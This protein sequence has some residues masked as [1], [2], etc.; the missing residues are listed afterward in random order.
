[1]SVKHK[2]GPWRI[3]SVPT[4]ATVNE[5]CLIV[6]EDGTPI[7][8]IS[9]DGGGTEEEI[10]ECVANAHLIEAAPN[11]EAKFLDVL[12]ELQVLVD[13]WAEHRT[14]TIEP[15]SVWAARVIA[16]IERVTG[17]KASDV[18]RADDGCLRERLQD[19]NFREHVLDIIA[20]IEEGY[21]DDHCCD[22]DCRSNGCSE[23]VG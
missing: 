6:A 2:P 11:L 9:Y 8:A 15:G 14:V 4:V 16:T 12:A 20:A 23:V 19:K 7:C 5:E 18:P 13:T 21:D 10:A 17:L 3:D 22:D 1:M